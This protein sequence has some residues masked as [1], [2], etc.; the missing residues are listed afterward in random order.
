[1]KVN[2]DLLLK[3]T[4]TIINQEIDEGINTVDENA[5]KVGKTNLGEN[6]DT[7]EYKP[8]PLN[9]II[10][11][12]KYKFNLKLLDENFEDTEDEEESKEGKDNNKK[13]DQKIKIKR[14]KVI[15]EEEDFEKSDS[16]SDDYIEPKKYKNQKAREPTLIPYKYAFATIN[17]GNLF[18]NKTRTIKGD[19]QKKGYIEKL[20]EINEYENSYYDFEL[21]EEMENEEEEEENEE[22]EKEEKK[23]SKKDKGKE[24]EI[25]NKEIDQKLKNLNLEIFGEEKLP[26]SDEAIGEPP[27]KKI[28]LSD[29]DMD[30]D[31]EDDLDIDP[32]NNN[33]I[34]N[35]N[36]E[37]NKYQFS[38]HI[39]NQVKTPIDMITIG[40]SI[41]EFSSK[42]TSTEKI[43]TSPLN[44][45]IKKNKLQILLLK[46]LNM[47]TQQIQL[48]K[49]GKFSLNDYISNDQKDEVPTAMAVDNQDY[50]TNCSIWL[51]TNKGT[52]MKMPIC[53]KPSQDCQGI[54]ISSEE[55]GI[56]ALDVYENCLV[57]GHINGIMQIWEG[58]KL[59]DKINDVKCEILQVRFI[60]VNKKKKKYEFIYSDSNGNVNY[61]KR[62]KSFMGKNLNEEISS[63]KEF[64]IFKISIF[65]KEK[66][67]K[68]CKKKNLLIGLAS[69]NSV[70]LYKIRPNKL[71]NKKIAV[72]EIPYS[73]IGVFIFDCD[74]GYGYPPF[75]ELNVSNETE[76]KKLL[77]LENQLVEEGK[78][79]SLLFVVSYGVVIKLFEI[80]FKKNYNV[81]FKEIGHYITDSP[82]NKIGFI[83]KSN[84][85]LIDNNKSLKIINTFCFKNEIFKE[86][87][88]PTK[89]NII[90]HEEIEL[91]KFDILKQ[92]NLYYYNTS[93]EKILGDFNY[94]NSSIIFDQ[95]I[96]ILTKQKLLLYKKYRWDEIIS[97]LS[98][99]EKY[100][101]MIWLATFI[102]GKNKN[103]FD[104]NDDKEFNISL[105]ESLYIFLIKGLTKENNYKELRMYIE[106]CVK[107]GRYRDIYKA[108]KV[109]KIKKLDIYLY[110]Y[111]ADFIINGSFS[112]FEF[113]LDFLIDMINYFIGK[114]EI[115]LLSKVLLKL[116]VNN[117]NR[118]EILKILEENEIINP[119]IYAKM[120]ER[121]ATEIDYFKPIEYLYTLFEKKLIEEKNKESDEKQDIDEKNTNIDINKD[122]DKYKEKE[123]NNK[124]N[125]KKEKKI[126]KVKLEYFKL[127][128]EHDMKYYY[129]KTLTCND[130]RGHK[131]LWY[132]NKC[133]NNEEYPKN[134][135]LP[136]KAFEETFKKIFLFLTLDNVMEILLKFDSFSYF[137]IITK[138]FTMPKLVKIMETEPDK[139][140][141]PFKGLESFVKQYLDDISIEYISEK[142]FYYQIKYFVD[143]KTKD[144][145]NSYYI[146]YDFYQM[147]SIL[148]N[149]RDI[150]TIFI[151]RG[152]MIDAIKFFINYEIGLEGPNLKKYEDPFA[153]H[154][155]P[156]KKELLYNKFCEKIEK[157]ILYLLKCLQNNQIFYETDL[158]D[159]F[160]LEGL[161]NHI[162]IKEYLSEYGKKYDELFKVKLNEYYKQNEF[163]TK[164]E[165]I[166]N[167]FKWIN[168]TL[169][170]TR[171][172]EK[173]QKNKNNILY[174][175]NFKKFLKTEFLTLANISVLDLYSLLERWYSNQ[176]TQICFS[177]DSDILKY[178][179]I[180]KYLSV[181][182]QHDEK[183]KNFEPYLF[184]KLELLA[185]N[186]HKEQ[187]IKIIERNRVLWT[188]KNL[189]FLVK[190]EVLD[191]GIFVSQK[192][193]D[194]ENCLKLTITQIEK[195]FSS[196]FKFLNEFIEEVNNDLIYIKLDEIKKYL[197]YGLA[198][199]ASWTEINS[200]NNEDLKNFWIK[201]LDMFYN[202]K[203]ELT[204]A[205]EDNKLG[206][207]Y[208]SETFSSIYQKIEQNIY[209]SIEYILNKMNDYIPLLSIVEVLCE[210][211]KNSNFKEYSKVFQRMFHSTRTTE[212]IFQLIYKLRINSLMNLEKGFL[213][214]IKGGVF[215]D[216]DECGYCTKQINLAE[217]YNQLQYFKCGHIYHTSCCPIE[218]GQYACYICRMDDLEESAFTDIPNLIFKKKEDFINNQIIENKSIFNVKKKKKEDKKTIMLNKLKSISKQRNNKFEYF[219]ANLKGIDN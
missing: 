54:I 7:G 181:Q 48:T 39:L 108:R 33:R 185:K 194:S 208:Q 205:N 146:K 84:L 210:K 63:C 137:Q 73:K 44:I 69:L 154:K 182:N 113:E 187:I 161:K 167:L 53:S 93:K 193:G 56:S 218:K 170:S 201:P 123:V 101:E 91:K 114:H 196:I 38:E 119:F 173:N 212:N 59:I 126:D 55:E 164:E 190:N 111:M 214:E 57:M 143:E 215:A 133:I 136:K 186:D 134:N 51:G 156:K 99:D 21:E 78:K 131:L 198:A 150:N 160:L 202:Y 110:Q 145:K 75:P 195:L 3:K 100:K 121:N 35:D 158:D 107:T 65:N 148:C 151:D 25:E 179:Y 58:Q 6:M 12:K 163:F 67:L 60:K 28:E 86:V 103:L 14:T 80:N 13:N 183:D 50:K 74:F 216:L 96:F 139:N 128:T 109:L 30:D 22:E 11:K 104:E 206:I 17:Q 138:L 130:Y 98:Q 5:L 116:N 49:E 178:V 171:K 52:L 155:M 76:K 118:P 106:F 197:D 24:K 2:K 117:L 72:I 200:Y 8:Q 70:S 219:K 127:M 81:S 172:M 32:F 9:K 153:C 92:K 140:K 203:N 46:Y 31:D 125:K 174:Y 159:L 90:H 147:T 152:T 27:I 89:L 1:M 157:N 79:E 15:K 16:E 66:N 162:K 47:K 68:I 102:L 77:V 166:K 199:S 188:N 132:I 19:F 204:K 95:N 189:Q 112:D 120:K 4:S 23:E 177:I 61:V 191:A 209:E 142:Y 10:Y 144:F 129:D 18:W 105:D 175:H 20:E 184:M 83:S 87:N 88:S 211:F 168:D 85:I 165:N 29:L 43:E 40:E 26:P 34:I 141:F 169:I 180:N 213:N 45:F 41:Y 192:C 37:D 115:V 36:S 176:V 122:E 42:K 82:I 71:E 207:K 62:S 97:N 149:K 64:P 94:L 217:E 135:S 124:K